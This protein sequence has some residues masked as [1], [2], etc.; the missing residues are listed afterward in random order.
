MTDDEIRDR[1]RKLDESDK[2]VTSWEAGFIENVCFKY[3]T[4]TLSEKQRSTAIDI[5]EKYGY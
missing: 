3:S 5:L 1:L 2:E 4:W